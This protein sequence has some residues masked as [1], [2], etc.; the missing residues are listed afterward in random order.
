[1]KLQLN[2]KKIEK[3]RERLGLTQN[4]LAEKMG[5]SKQ[6]MSYVITNKLIMHADSFGN[7][8]DIEPKDLIK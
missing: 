2:I 1:M 6:R 5:W 8:F 4:A 3:E 7:F